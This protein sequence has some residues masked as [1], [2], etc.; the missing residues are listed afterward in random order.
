M[1]NIDLYE[2]IGDAEDTDFQAAKEVKMKMPLVIEGKE[3]KTIYIA[4]GNGLSGLKVGA[5]PG[6]GASMIT[7]AMTEERLKLGLIS[8]SDNLKLKVV[9]KED[10]M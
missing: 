1:S 5:F 7:E 2:K 4:Q 10:E 8:M 9:E 3:L 6:D